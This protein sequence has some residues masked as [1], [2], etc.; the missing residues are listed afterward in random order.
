MESKVAENVTKLRKSRN[1]TQRE[2]A[3][4]L[5]VSPAAVSKWESNDA[6]PDIAML[7]AIA[8]YFEV[9]LDYIM[10]RELTKK[11]CLV[12]LQN[13]N[14]AL[15]VEELLDEVGYI[16][17]IMTDSYLDMK[18]FLEAKH[19]KV[20]VLL[21][22]G[23]GEENSITSEKLSQLCKKHEIQSMSIFTKSQAQYGGLLKMLMSLCK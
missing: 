13:R 16:A 1:L 11:N 18:E 8:D 2:L 10:G 4:I 21:R 17:L 7:V 22:F 6:I 5:G 9:T 12:F 23:I 15:Y 20:S 3:D 14:D 19:E